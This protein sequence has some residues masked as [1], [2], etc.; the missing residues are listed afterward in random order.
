MRPLRLVDLTSNGLSQQDTSAA[1]V[2]FGGRVAS[3][4]LELAPESWPMPLLV[5][6]RYGALALFAAAVDITVTET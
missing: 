3:G 2:V 5:H 1:V 4:D 6:E